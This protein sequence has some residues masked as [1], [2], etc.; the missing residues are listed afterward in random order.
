MADKTPVP[1]SE[2]RAWLRR[3]GHAVGSRGHISE[4]LIRDFNHRHHR[5][6]YISENPWSAHN[7]ESSEQPS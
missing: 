5:K 4:Q 3:R 6:I 1:L 2:V 7:K